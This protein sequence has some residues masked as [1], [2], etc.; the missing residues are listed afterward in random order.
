MPEHIEPRRPPAHRSPCAPVCPALRW[1]APPRSG[2]RSPPLRGGPTQNE[3]VTTIQ[4]SGITDQTGQTAS[5]EIILQWQE[6]DAAPEG[7]EQRWSVGV[8][9]GTVGLILMP[10]TY[11]ATWML[12][13]GSPW[14]ELWIVPASA[15]VLTIDAIR[16]A[17]AHTPVS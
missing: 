17:G 14:T 1:G 8:A 3:R 7:R 4:Q 16:T 9:G 13:S 10:G 2:T 15:D 11:E 12:T 6:P 5:G